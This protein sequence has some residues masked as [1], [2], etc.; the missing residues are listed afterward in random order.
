MFPYLKLYRSNNLLSDITINVNNKSYA[1]SKIILAKD[2]TLTGV[3]ETDFEVY[4]DYVY[5]NE[6]FEVS[7]T[8]FWNL[9]NITLLSYVL[10]ELHPKNFVILL[11]RSIEYELT[12]FQDIIISTIGVNILF[13]NSNKD[14]IAFEEMYFREESLLEISLKW[15]KFDINIRK[16][17]WI[18]IVS[19]LNWEKISKQYI[20]DK[21]L[22]Q[23]DIFDCD[24]VS[25]Y[26]LEKLSFMNDT[27][28]EYS[29]ILKDSVI[30]EANNTWNTV[31]TKTN[32]KKI[33]LSNEDISSQ[34][35][36]SKALMFGG[37]KRKKDI[38]MFDSDCL[39]LEKV[40][41]TEQFLQR[42]R[43]ERI[44]NYVY[45][46]GGYDK[47]MEGQVSSDFLRY[48]ISNKVV[49]M[50]PYKM[51]A[52]RYSFASCVINDV[53]FAFGGK[54]GSRTVA[55]TEKFSLEK[56][57]WVKGRCTEAVKDHGFDAIVARNAVFLTPG[58]LSAL[59]RRYDPREGGISQLEKI[60][61][62]R[63]MCA[64][65]KSGDSIIVCG[66]Y[67]NISRKEC[68]LY[69]IRNNN[70]TALSPLPVAVYGARSFFYNDNVYVFG[71]AIDGT[72][73]TNKIQTLNIS[74]NKWS[75]LDI[76]MQFF[77]DSF[78]LITY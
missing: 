25:G 5:N 15:V 54:Q 20:Q 17:Y 48:D 77:N 63:Y 24:I 26:I 33:S 6:N 1:L 43:C 11:R 61:T 8:T 35:Y 69:D 44:S 14:Y 2:Y 13:E 31:N 68:H 51:A 70:W 74:T 16:N 22:I 58:G 23:D 56:M 12:N 52:P 60:P 36:F 19:L 66:G 73:G 65:C 55:V 47:L 9:L 76:R 40:G 34:V 78:S 53:L 28:I 39:S 72:K 29:E 38:Y 50:L 30:P 10:H 71:G 45:I 32:Q 59:I 67:S 27:L 57:R 18:S 75:V 46:F 64:S 41:E 42:H 4:L 62:G 3:S 49:T 21:V 37:S 7:N